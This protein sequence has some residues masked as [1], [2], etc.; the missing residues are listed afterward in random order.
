MPTVVDV[1]VFS[2]N[3]AAMTCAF[4]VGYT[5]VA[6]DVALTFREMENAD[7][8]SVPAGWAILTQ[9]GVSSGTTTRLA[10]IWKR[11]VG[12][13]TAPS[14]ADVG[15]HQVGMMIIIR[16]CKTSGNPWNI[17]TSTTE[18]TA[19]TSVSIPTVTTTAANCLILQAF[20]T[21]QDVNSSA[22]VTTFANASL[23]NVAER[24]DRWVTAGTGGGFWMGSGEKAVAGAT[25]AMTATLLLTSNFKAL[26]TIAMEGAADVAIP[27]PSTVVN[28]AVARSR[29]Y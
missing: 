13:D 4:P 3:A 20:S 2:S 14:L 26:M 24:M 18:L 12:G 22:G 1:G 28:A 27:P 10:V 11:L 16:G 23:T 19:D 8:P 21:G 6:D 7:T 5:A 9:Q 15:D 17:F 29:F 25:G